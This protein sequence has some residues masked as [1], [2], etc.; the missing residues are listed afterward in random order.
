[1]AALKS[2]YVNFIANSRSR[3]RERDDGS[4]VMDLLRICQRHRRSHC[5]VVV[6]VAVVVGWSLKQTGR[7]GVVVV[8][9]ISTMLLSELE[10]R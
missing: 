4:L 10:W 8:Y 9:F 1:M 7:I 3:R 6:V 5:L 2:R